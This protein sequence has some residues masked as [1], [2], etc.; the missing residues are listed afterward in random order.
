M[1]HAHLQY[2]AIAIWCHP[3][4]K[5]GH[6][7]LLLCYANCAMLPVVE[8]WGK[9]DSMQAAKGCLLNYCKINTNQS[10]SCLWRFSNNST[11]ASRYFEEGYTLS[12]S[13]RHTFTHHGLAANMN[14]CIASI[15][16]SL[17]MAHPCQR[18]CGN[19]AILSLL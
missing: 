15:G 19:L 16:I 4:L 9:E 11:G 18:T 14:E 17:E 3:Q 10:V 7:A 12:N 6:E 8:V 2:E 1:C 5:G 13:I